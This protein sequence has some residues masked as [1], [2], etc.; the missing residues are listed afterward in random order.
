M[1]TDEQLCVAWRSSTAALRQG[2][3]HRVRRVVEQRQRYLNEFER[4]NPRG[5]KV[6]LASTDSSACDPGVYL[7]ED[8]VDLPKADWDELTRGHGA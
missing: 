5:V 3:P 2:S 8:W 1:L 6:W 7:V 4:R